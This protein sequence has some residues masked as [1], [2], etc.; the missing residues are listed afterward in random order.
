MYKV[1]KNGVSSVTNKRDI[2]LKQSI[3]NKISIIDTSEGGALV[4]AHIPDYVPDGQAFAAI[5]CRCLNE[6]KKYYT[7]VQL[8]KLK[9]K[10]SYAS[11]SRLRAT[12]K[13]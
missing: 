1:I 5:I 13:S 7:L 9:I 6:N 11:K 4:V 2:T 3:S 8:K 12:P 10:P